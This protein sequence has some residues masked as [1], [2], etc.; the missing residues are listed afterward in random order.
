MKGRGDQKVFVLSTPTLTLPPAYRQAGIERGR[1]GLF[2]RFEI[3]FVN[4]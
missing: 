4:L 3:S 1:W 2:E